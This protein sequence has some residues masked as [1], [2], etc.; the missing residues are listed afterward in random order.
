M[1]YTLPETSA[2]PTLSGV[3]AANAAEEQQKFASDV[4]MVRLNI[5]RW[6]EQVRQKE[7]YALATYAQG[8]K[9]FDGWECYA[10]EKQYQRLL[11]SA[12]WLA[13]LQELAQKGY[14]IT[15]IAPFNGT[16]SKLSFTLV[17]SV[18]K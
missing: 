11:S 4:R 9:P 6:V 17:W 13:L 7:K 15:H 3:A 18:P 8:S 10:T 1:E 14:A 5:T 16:W 12:P 2:L